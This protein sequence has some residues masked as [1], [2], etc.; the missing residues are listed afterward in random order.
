MA[1]TFDNNRVTFEG[2]VNEGEIA[3]LKEHLKA[4][5][6]ASL[7]FDFKECGDLHTGVIQVLCAYR[8]THGC[9]WVFNEEDSA[10]KKALKGC[11]SC[12]DNRH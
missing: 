2:L 7:E 10:Y 12:E 6:P 4:H 9:D 5:A 3:P 8:L 1:V 11:R